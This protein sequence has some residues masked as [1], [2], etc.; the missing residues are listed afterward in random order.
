RWPG[1]RR[2][3][4]Q[5]RGEDLAADRER[6]HCA[7]GV[8]GKPDHSASLLARPLPA[9]SFFW[10]LII[11]RADGYRV[12]DQALGQAALG[13]R[14]RGQVRGPQAGD[15]V[16]AALG[17]QEHDPG[18]VGG[19]LE[20]A[21][22]AKAEVAGP[23]LLAGEAAGH[24]QILSVRSAHRSPPARLRDRPAHMITEIFR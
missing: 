3:G 17:A 12:D 19:D 14:I 21:R 20:R 6:G 10:W 13:A 16:A 7:A 9:G 1:A 2:L 18:P 5:L 24:E 8:R 11:L 22:D 23:G 4:S 15:G